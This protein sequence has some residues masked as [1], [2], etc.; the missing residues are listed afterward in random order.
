MQS[1]GEKIDRREFLSRGIAASAVSALASPVRGCGEDRVARIAIT[2]D[3]EMS[4]H[5]PK[6]G[7]TEW[8]YQKGNLDE[9]TKRY[10]VEAGRIVRS[11][12]GVIHYF[13]V[14]RVL[15]QA[16]VDWLKQLAADGHPLG[17]HTYD[18]VNLK[19][20]TPTEAQFRFRRSPWLV[21][22]KTVAEVIVENIRLT[23]MAL[24]E[25]TGIR[26]RGFRAPGGFFNGLADRPDL[27]RML[28]DLG[29]RWASTKYP[30]HPLGKVGQPPDKAIYDGI[31][32]AQRQAQ[33]FQYPSGLVEVPMSPISDVTAFR[34]RLWKLP[35]FLRA[36]RQAVSWAIDNAAVFDF[37][38]HPSCLV[39]EDPD[40]AIVHEICRMV[41][42]AGQKATLTDLA[43]IADTV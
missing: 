28:L 8:D 26:V 27:Q 33:P 3:L 17:N 29:F 19:A 23:T 38:A 5:Y 1:S 41:K 9:P 32:A 2:L 6:R 37:L 22:G 43:A 31:V 10:A 20:R 35:W 34:S 12:G 39:V 40:F 36:T 7:M 18:H 15:E 11:Y 14:G 25:R 24:K 16:N 21:R 42:A 13:C 4:R 30:R